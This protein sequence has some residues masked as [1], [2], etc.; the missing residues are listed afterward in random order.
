MVRRLRQ[1]V[2][3]WW[4]IQIN[5]TDPKGA[6]RGVAAGGFFK[7]SND[8][9]RGVVK[10]GSGV[11]GCLQSVCSETLSCSNL[12]GPKVSTC[13]AGLTMILVPIRFNG[14]FLGCV[15]GDGFLLEE[16]LLE[17]Q[18]AVDLYLLFTFKDFIDC[19]MPICKVINYRA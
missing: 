15:V 6:V 7:P 8:L 5:F 9:C 3:K 11:Q 18:E 14:D 12:D 10:T 17:Q 2:G 13:H 19:I 1:I 16:T 4:N